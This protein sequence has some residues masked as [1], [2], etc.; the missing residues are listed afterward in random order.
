MR[1]LF[2]ST[3][4]AT[5]N[6]RGSDSLEHHSGG[7]LRA[8]RARRR[9]TRCLPRIM[10][11]RVGGGVA[12]PWRGVRAGSRRRA[13]GVWGNRS[14]RGAECGHRRL[15][16]GRRYRRGAAARQLR[17]VATPQGPG[18]GAG[19]LHGRAPDAHREALAQR[20]GGHAERLFRVEA[21][22][23]HGSYIRHE[24]LAQT[25]LVFELN[26]RHNEPQIPKS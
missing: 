12:R 10:R 23:V 8:R 24:R 5:G 14:D 16:A 7:D 20:A 26:T 19:R 1:A 18:E 13:W 6:D 15:G 2:Q 3:A 25:S 21:R 22:R 4:H 9:G 17:P 11:R